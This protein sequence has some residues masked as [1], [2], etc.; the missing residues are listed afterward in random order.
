MFASILS[1]VLPA[2]G[3]RCSQRWNAPDLDRS[4]HQTLMLASV[5]VCEAGQI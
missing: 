5:L 1:R 2:L 3:S 4:S